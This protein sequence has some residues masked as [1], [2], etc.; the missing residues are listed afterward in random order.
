MAD[1]ITLAN[2]KI[3]GTKEIAGGVHLA[4]SLLVDITGAAIA[5][6][7]AAQM[8]EVQENPTANTLLDRVKVLR[9]GIVL[10]AGD[11]NIGNVDVVSS[12]LPTGAATEITVDRAA[13]AV[14]AIK[15]RTGGTV[16]EAAP[17]LVEG[18]TNQPDSLNTHGAKRV[19][20][21]NPAGGDLI[22][23]ESAPFHNGAVTGK[24]LVSADPAVITSWFLSNKHAT[25]IGYL[26][27][28]DAAS[29]GA[30][31]LGATVPVHE[32]DLKA[33]QRATESG[34]SLK[35]EDGIVIAVTTASNG[36]TPTATGWGVNLGHV[37]SGA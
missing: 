9:T 19:V 32:I 29:T 8:G 26:Q 28:F 4:K 31:T 3:V 33:G 25:D 27:F 35:F 22:P 16:S 17:A 21:Q 20:L 5:P 7:T 12:A 23:D 14:E 13:D 24:V 30:V 2:G 6:V 36:A 18:A 10:A 11:N 34:L 1:N 37:P 15:D